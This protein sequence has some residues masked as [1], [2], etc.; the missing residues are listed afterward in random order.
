MKKCKRKGAGEKKLI[1]K[2]KNPAPGDGANQKRTP[3]RNPQIWSLFSGTT[4]SPQEPKLKSRSM[5]FQRRSPN[6]F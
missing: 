5:R 1:S 6:L 2:K 4:K 3:F